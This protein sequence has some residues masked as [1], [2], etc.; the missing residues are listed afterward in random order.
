M[1]KEQYL[2]LLFDKL[3]EIVHVKYLV[4]RPLFS[5]RGN[6][7]FIERLRRVLY[8]NDTPV[9]TFCD[10]LINNYNEVTFS[11]LIIS[12]L[13][14]H[15]PHWIYGYKRKVGLKLVKEENRLVGNEPDLIK[16]LNTYFYFIQVTYGDFNE[17]LMF[18]GDEKDKILV[19]EKEFP[20]LG[21]LK[22]YDSKEN[23]ISFI[24]LLSTITDIL[25]GKRFAILLDNDDVSDL[26]EKDRIIKGVELV[27]INKE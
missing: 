27:G 26:P 4:G 13:I 10:N 22:P 6:V 15:T 11:S 8:Y 7:Q 19:L 14:G 17:V 20:E 9:D 24:S 12:A 16:I 3:F 18:T 23:G 2:E 1:T 21:I 5:D 25:C